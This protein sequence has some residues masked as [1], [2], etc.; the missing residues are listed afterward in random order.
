[1]SF[2]RRERVAL[3]FFALLILA[4]V[5]LATTGNPLRTPS[6]YPASS[7]LEATLVVEA[8]SVI[9]PNNMLIGMNDYGPDITG[10]YGDRVAYDLFSD[11][12]DPPP[13]IMPC[14]LRTWS[15]FGSQLGYDLGFGYRH[16]IFNGTTYEDAQSAAFYNWTYL[17]ILQSVSLNMFARW[18]LTFTGCPISL[19]RSGGPVDPPKN[20]TVYAEV[21]AHVYRHYREGWPGG[22]VQYHYSP[23]FVEIGNEPDLPVFWNGTQTEFFELYG[24]VSLR[25]RQLYPDMRIGGP[26]LA[27]IS[28]GWAPAFLSYVKKN[29]LPLDF[30]SWHCYDNNSSKVVDAILLGK[31]AAQAQGFTDVPTFL[32]EWGRGLD[33]DTGWDS[34]DAALHA[35]NVLIGAQNAGLDGLC[36][37]MAKD[38]PI[39]YNHSSWGWE[40]NFGLL[41]RNSTPKPTYYC[42]GAFREME[43]GFGGT[44]KVTESP[45]FLR[46]PNLN[47]AASKWSYDSWGTDWLTHL[48]LIIVNNENRSVRIGVLLNGLPASWSIRIEA[49]EMSASSISVENGWIGMQNFPN[50]VQFGSSLVLEPLELGPRSITVISLSL[51]YYHIYL[52]PQFF[53]V[54]AVLEITALAGILLIRKI[55]KGLHR[56]QNYLKK[57][58]SVLGEYD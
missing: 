1:M 7:E 56:W 14:L 20:N 46:S 25:L 37:A 32:N 13:P 28:S 4:Q 15:A 55:E 11:W 19:S 53:L 8:G 45:P 22:T 18:L 38:A 44:I 5:N 24:N 31:Q 40:A 58:K 23:S 3:A 57:S 39:A 50:L 30:F 54:M 21:V 33:N 42:L 6:E 26:A 51:V 9:G 12:A 49:K 41:T 35:A 2:M 47:F 36:Y 52:T 34:I 10:L 48:K 17:D 16:V 27:N 43:W 29:N